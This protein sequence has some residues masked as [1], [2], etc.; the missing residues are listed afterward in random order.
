M[1][2]EQYFKKEKMVAPCH[3]IE[4]SNKLSKKNGWSR[5]LHPLQFVAWFFLALF[6][7]LY[8]GAMVPNFPPG[9]WQQTTTIINGIILLIHIIVHIISITVDP[10]DVAVRKKNY[11]GP[12]PTFDRDKHAHVIENQTCHLCLVKVAPRS[13]HC[14][15]CNKCVSDFDHHCKWLNNCVGGRNYKLFIACVTSALVGSL[16]IFVSAVILIIAFYNKESWFYIKNSNDNSLFLWTAT[17]ISSLVSSSTGVGSD[18]QFSS[19]AFATFVPS[20][21]ITKTEPTFIVFVPVNST[22]FLVVIFIII[23]LTFLAIGLLGHLLIFHIYLMC[24]GLSTYDYIIQKR[25][26]ATEASSKLTQCGLK[27]HLKD[28]GKF[29]YSCT[30]I[31]TRKANQISPVRQDGV[32]KKSEKEEW[33]LQQNIETKDKSLPEYLPKPNITANLDNGYVLDNNGDYFLE[34]CVGDVYIGSPHRRQ[35]YLEPIYKRTKTKPQ[36]TISVEEKQEKNIENE[37][38]STLNKGE[39]SS[40]ILRRHKCPSPSPLLSP[41]IEGEKLT[42]TGRLSWKS[43]S[44]SE[45]SLNEFDDESE[46][47]FRTNISIHNNLED[48]WGAKE[49]GSLSNLFFQSNQDIE[50]TDQLHKEIHED[51][52][53][54]EIVIPSLPCQECKEDHDHEVDDIKEQKDT[55]LEGDHWAFIPHI[56]G[57]LFRK[58]ENNNYNTTIGAHMSDLYP[59]N[60]TRCKSEDELMLN[61]RNSKLQ[62]R[63]S[64]NEQQWQ[65]HDDLSFTQPINRYVLNKGNNIASSAFLYIKESERGLETPEVIISASKKSSH[66]DSISHAVF[67]HRDCWVGDMKY[68]HNTKQVL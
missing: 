61:Q 68:K 9:M 11:K 17:T 30:Q 26:T 32:M 2:N 31:F 40:G 10:A 39:T 51:N 46:S 34:H 63:F 7:F 1:L 33:E 62:R 37:Q 58:S 52:G 5:P 36:I 60:L 4:N 3:K 42:G 45:Q 23:A 50:T 22:F 56:D 67:Q 49:C 18:V 21:N 54:Q 25:E 44:V 59:Y 24:K 53:F 6:S 8:F 41:I 65:L 66:P 55:F 12:L 16:Y 64:E 57:R 47:S 27:H 15:V 29:Y 19:Y 43:R 13:K 38:A 20:T 14:S 28:E 48:S 35:Q